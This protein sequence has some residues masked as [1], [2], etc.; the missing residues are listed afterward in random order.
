MRVMFQCMAVA[1]IVSGACAPDEP[2]EC[3]PWD[4]NGNWPVGPTEFVQNYCGRG[5]TIVDEPGFG[6]GVISMCVPAPAQGCDPCPWAADETDA[7]LREQLD[8]LFAQSGCPANYEPERF[9]RGCFASSPE[10]D[11]CC[12]TAEYV[13]D[14]SICDPLPSESP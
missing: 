2:R 6:R 10:T 1:A 5:P 11:E 13:T 8:E 12:Y 7:R 3:Y 9:I 4:G 14:E